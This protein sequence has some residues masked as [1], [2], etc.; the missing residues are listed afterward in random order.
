MAYAFNP[1]RHRHC[2]SETSLVYI[3]KFQDSQGSKE[4]DADSKQTK[5]KLK[6]KRPDRTL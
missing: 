3:I 5:K 2:E 6:D 1:N 4:R